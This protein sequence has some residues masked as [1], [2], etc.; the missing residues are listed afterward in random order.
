VS[1]PARLASRPAVPEAIAGIEPRPVGVRGAVRA[2]P[3]RRRHLEKTREDILVATS[4]VLQ[5]FGYQG[6]RIEE[7]CSRAGI[8]RGAFYHH[9]PSKEAAIVAL[10][11]RS[12]EPLVEEYGLIEV[13]AADQPVRMIALEMAAVMRW[14]GSGAPTARAYL[15]DMM[16]VPEADELRERIQEM[17]EARTRTNLEPLVASGELTSTDLVST[18]RAFV[19]MTRQTATEWILGRV[20]DLD[21]ALREV[22]RLALLG[23]GVEAGRAEALAEEAA[24]YRP[25]W[26]TADLG[27]A[28]VA[29]EGFGPAPRGR[30]R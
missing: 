13:A 21:L 20:P 18:I 25:A 30:A 2:A 9:F 6:S 7:I 11:E 15:V 28:P 12:L 19:G 10:V 16:G 23:V 27:A 8:S 26:V 14:V 1:V 4:K 5:E 29:A 22:V 3:R 24:S 17:F